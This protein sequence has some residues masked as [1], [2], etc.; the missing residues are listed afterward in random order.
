[1]YYGRVM[2]PSSQ[3][4]A[5]TYSIHKFK[6]LAVEDV[7]RASRWQPAAEAFCEVWNG[8]RVNWMQFEQVLVLL[9]NE[10]VDTTKAS[11]PFEDRADLFVIVSKL[12]KIQES[13]LA[14]Y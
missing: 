3:S 4:M 6:I 1:M 8:P 10:S 12:I 7:C 11:K 13:A 14:T 9:L 5:V 2:H